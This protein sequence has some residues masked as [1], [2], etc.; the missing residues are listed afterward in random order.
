[1]R[2]HT[3]LHASLSPNHPLSSEP[4]KLH[5]LLCSLAVLPQGNQTRALPSRLPGI[6]PPFCRPALSAS[7]LRNDLTGPG[8]LCRG[9]ER[10]RYVTRWMPPVVVPLDLVLS[11][12]C[13]LLL[14]AI[15]SL[16]TSCHPSANECPTLGPLTADHFLGIIVTRADWSARPSH[17]SVMHSSGRAARPLDG[18]A[19]H[20]CHR[21]HSSLGQP[22]HASGLPSCC[23]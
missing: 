9:Q 7:W 6:L 15:E 13:N 1:M 22:C 23:I 19:R 4:Q 14:V 5:C 18:G 11:E 2:R 12:R 10:S 17:S 21:Y 3:C 16:P 8:C 20:I